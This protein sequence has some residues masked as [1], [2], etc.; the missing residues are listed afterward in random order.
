MPRAACQGAIKCW[1]IRAPLRGN[2]GTPCAASWGNKRG[3][4]GAIVPRP[5]GN[6]DPPR[7]IGTPLLGNRGGPNCPG[8]AAVLP[9]YCPAYCPTMPCRGY[10]FCPAKGP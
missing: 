6:W 10:P 9:R 4:S 5:R 7:A 3:N 1:G 8:G 2:R